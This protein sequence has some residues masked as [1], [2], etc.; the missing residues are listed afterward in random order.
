MSVNPFCSMRARY[1]LIIFTSLNF[2]GY[3]SKRL[4]E[5][6]FHISISSFTSFIVLYV[7]PSVWLWYQCKRHCVPFSL[8]INRKE[9]FNFLQ[10]LMITVML[11]LFSYGYLVVYM[12][13]FAW[14]T[15]NFIINILREPIMGSVD[16]YIY[17]FITLVLVTPII[18]EFIFRGFLF[19]R[20]AAKWGTAKGVIIVAL[21]FGC[22]HIDFLGAVVFSIVL[23]IVYIRT[24]SLLMPISIH[25][26]NNGI[27]LFT[28]FMVSKEE[29]MSL[30]DFTN[31]TTFLTGLII[32]IIG[33]NLV[34]IFLFQNRRY[35]S[36]NIPVVSGN[37][38][39]EF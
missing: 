6:A 7:F 11:C 8:F 13:S 2:I 36:K 32:F 27:V 12:Y 39:R 24:K 19:Q 25:I 1:F 5:S 10:V 34:L 30:A 33:L 4:L 3:F 18:C 17:Q 28:S 23:S 37:R 14:I 15:P 9:Q 35:M 20:F 16:G 38:V 22:F 31:H 26:L 21:L 29:R